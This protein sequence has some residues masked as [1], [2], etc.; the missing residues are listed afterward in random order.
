MQYCDL[1]N[2]N[3]IDE[4]EKWVKKQGGWDA[5]VVGSGS[6]DP[7]GLFE[8]I[9]FDEWERSITENFIGQF[10]LIHGLLPM[11]KKNAAKQAVVLMFAGGGTNN[12]VVRYSAYTISKIAA[13]KMC[14]LLDAENKDTIFTIVGPGWV[15]TK[16]HA[17]TL[18][19]K[20]KAGKNY[21][22]TIEM[23]GEKKCFPIEKV[24]DCC[25]WLINAPREIVSGR[26]FSA[27]HDPWETTEIEKIK[28]NENNFKLR[29]FGNEQFKTD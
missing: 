27:V 6:Q 17:S 28:F 19:N 15:D 24:V 29:R 14:E 2:R 11:S 9:D 21:Q 13:I 8:E 10:R 16:I 18:N 25:D 12:A 22:K 5:L 20:T 3:S 23:I 4:C 7:I 26:N 1:L